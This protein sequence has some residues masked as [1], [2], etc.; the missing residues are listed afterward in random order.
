MRYPK[1]SENKFILQIEQISE[2]IIRLKQIDWIHFYVR[3]VTWSTDQSRVHVCVL[4]KFRIFDGI[5]Q[6]NES[7]KGATSTK[8]TGDP[9]S[10]TVT[11]N[12]FLI[13]FQ[14]TS[15]NVGYRTFS[16]SPNIV[17]NIKILS[18]S[19]SSRTPVV[20]PV[21]QASSASSDACSCRTLQ[22][23]FE[24]PKGEFQ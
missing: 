5:N 11:Q 8:P 6:D 16:I 7:Y 17:A 23:C 20:E 12:H 2:K 14:G 13:S 3:T 9:S 1:K 18:N 24:H 4:Q 22:T 21:V 15:T 19:A 10:N